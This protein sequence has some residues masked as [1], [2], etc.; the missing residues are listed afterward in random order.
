M[1][2]IK[3]EF[4]V[5]NEQYDSDDN[6]NNNETNAEFLK[7]V[8]TIEDFLDCEKTKYLLEQENEWKKHSFEEDLY[9][10]YTK[11]KNYSNEILD[12]YFSNNFCNFNKLFNIV[13]ANIEPKYDLNIFYE[14]SFLAQPLIDKMDDF[15]NQLKINRKKEIAENYDKKCKNKGKLFNWGTKKHY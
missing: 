5:N 14:N 3:K 8:F 13:N 1:P 9:N 4:A 10:F 11:E 2:S 12:S 6:N 15:N 7:D